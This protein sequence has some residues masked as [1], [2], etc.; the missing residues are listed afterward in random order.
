[1]KTAAGSLVWRNFRAADGV[2]MPCR[3]FASV[4]PSKPVCR[5]QAEDAR[6][7]GFVTTVLRSNVAI[8][9]MISKIVGNVGD[10]EKVGWTA[11]YHSYFFL[12]F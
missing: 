6:R 11:V 10:A 12:Q 9:V 8:I 2:A 5:S 7:S 3:F 4:V 1:M